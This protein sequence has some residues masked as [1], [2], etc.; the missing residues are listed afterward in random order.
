MTGPRHLTAAQAAKALGVSARALRLYE[1]KGL[2]R[3]GRTASGW[4]TYG[5]GDLARLHQVLAL[6]ALGLDLQ[7]VGEL[8]A[9]GR[10]SFAE[11]LEAQE[12][13]L[14]IRR[15]EAERALELIRRARA[16]LKAGQSLS[17]DDLTTLTRE[18]V[19]SEPIDEAAM[20]EV[21]APLIAKHH[22]PES[23]QALKDRPY[24][25]AEVTAQWEALIADAKAAQAKGDPTT[26]QAKDVG[27][28]WKSLVDRFTGGD[29][30]VAR[31][32]KAIWTDAFADPAAAPKLPFGPDL[33]DFVRRAQ[34][35]DV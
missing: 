25:Q 26:P 28:R 5:Q 20:Q 23:L 19:M 17:V 7:R 15:D 18:T 8:V 32:T 33:M 24:D 21:F 12:L 27:R 16:R 35:A 4:R 6:K 14:L 11:V 1:A 34:E 10:L 22:T 2:V 13:A 3:P 9:G 31:R 30:E 29:P